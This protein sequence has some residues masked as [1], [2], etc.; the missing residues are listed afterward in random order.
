RGQEPRHPI[1]KALAQTIAEHPQPIEPYHRL[2]EA[3]RMDQRIKRHATYAD[4]LHYCE[5]SATPVGRMVLA[6]WGYQ[7]AERQRLSDATCIALQ[8]ANFW[9]DVRRDFAMGRIY[10]PLEDMQ[11]FGYAEGELAAGV[12]NLNFKRLL[13]FEVERTRTLFQEGLKLVDMVEPE[14]RLD[15]RLFTSG[16]MAVL[17]AIERQDYDVLSK[18]PVVGPWRKFRL[19]SGALARLTAQRLAS[20]FRRG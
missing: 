13:Q 9:Q 12:C 1:L 15:L 10:I 16:G 2:I 4:V 8:L 7:D 3:N 6:V 19:A 20:P 17:D 18:R 14:L 11:R 5:H